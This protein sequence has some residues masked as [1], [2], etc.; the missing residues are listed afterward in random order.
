MKNLKKVIAALIVF[1]AFTTTSKAQVSATATATATIITPISI[2]RTAHMNFGNV[3]V[4][5]G[6]GT[7]VLAPALTSPGRTPSGDVTLPATAGTVSAATFTVTGAT[8]YTYALTLPTSSITL[9]K[10]SSTETMT[11][12]TF[13]SSLT[14]SQG[15]L[16]NGS[17]NFAVG[18]TLT[19]GGSQVA[20]VY[21]SGNFTVT[22][23]YN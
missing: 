22:V 15:T 14:N 9:T 7:V 11:V 21:S 17:D 16:N 5:T 10:A 2:S 18:A 19:V 23:N 12:G 6:G 3:A 4:S 1:A 8:N 13:T 20:G